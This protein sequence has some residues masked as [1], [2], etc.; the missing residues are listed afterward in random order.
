MDFLSCENIITSEDYW[1]MII[2][3]KNYAD[4]AAPLCFQD[5]NSEWRIEYRERIEG[6]RL[7]FS[8]YGYFTI[9]KLYGLMDTT[10]M[11]ATGI[12]RVQTQPTL[13]L[14]GENVMIGIID[15]GIDYRHEAF[16]D[17]FGNS[18]I[19]S[20]W[21]QTIEGNPPEGLAYGSEY[22]NE[23][24]TRAIKSDNPYEI[25]PSRDEVGHGTYVAGTAAGSRNINGTFT[26][27]AP[28]SSIVVV[29][30]KEA[31]QYL[32]DFYIIEKNAHAYA[33]ND[34]MLGVK[35][36]RNMMVKYAMPMVLCIGLGTSNTGHT[37]DSPLGD[38]LEMLA[39]EDGVAV[40]CAM[41]NEGNERHHFYGTYEYN[42]VNS[43][44]IR[45]GDN[46]PGFCLEMWSDY[47]DKYSLNIISPLG[48]RIP[49]SSIL[50][51]QTRKYTFT[52]EN[53]VVYVD[54][55]LVETLSGRELIVMLFENPTPGI[56]QL[57]VTGEIVVNGVYN[58]WLPISE[59]LSAD[60]FFVS[61]DPNI[62]LTSP[63]DVPNV[64]SVGG[65]NHNLGIF[66]LNSGR[67][68]TASNV[69]KPD[70]VAPSVSV[71]CP[72]S[73]LNNEYGYRTG[74]SIGTAIAA[75]SAALML[76]WGIVRGNLKSMNTRDIKGYMIRGAR[77]SKGRVY[78][79]PEFG[80]GELDVYNIFLEI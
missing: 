14:F 45:V 33:E 55:S 42:N 77:R 70:V 1:D 63:A 12:T 5:V 60:T 78:P 4:D 9:P 56:W 54:Y 22:G 76:E 17:E 80:Y 28:K 37:G 7:S 62:T 51:G 47:P 72:L 10:A 21:D 75:G 25:V 79:S 15:T 64:I 40:V 27:V 46:E 74:T 58:L 6:R 66:Y 65:Y 29:K 49:I 11:D 67:G 32:R 20:I 44:E 50:L 24:I 31:K 71:Y 68:F 39:R 8:E 23:E 69:I 2:K 18:R 41:G 52:L 13:A 34:I 38:T 48:N 26:G 61:S 16:I 35:Y 73:G 30:L 3:R 53:T 59:F 19:L 57:E 43:V 36:I